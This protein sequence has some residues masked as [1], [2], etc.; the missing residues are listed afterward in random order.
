MRPRTPPGGGGGGGGG[1]GRGAPP[2]PDREKGE[3][4]VDGG[5]EVVDELCDVDE[6]VARR[7]W[8]DDV[9]RTKLDELVGIPERRA[10]N[11]PLVPER[12]CPL[13]GEPD[14]AGTEVRQDE[15]R[16]IEPRRSLL[17]HVES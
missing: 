6:I 14:F 10:V 9:L 12:P 16:H 17:E 15:V 1:V 2:P 7:D 4:A 8:E 13:D 11:V 5:E 3:R